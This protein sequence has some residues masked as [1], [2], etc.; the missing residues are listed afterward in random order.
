M[1]GSKFSP[2][3][4]G[5][6]ELTA[7]AEEVPANQKVY[8]L[9]MERCTSTGAPQIFERVILVTAM[10]PDRPA[11][12]YCRIKVGEVAYMYGKIFGD[13]EKNRKSIAR[14]ESASLGICN[15]F[16]E[17]GFEVIKS[18]AIAMPNDYQLLD[19]H[20][21]CLKYDKDSD[22]YQLQLYGEEN[23]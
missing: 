4:I 13:E 15:Y 14:S 12:L 20:A 21:A 6:A 19:G 3:L 16:E 2:F 22:L 23:D 1:T 18:A 10:A 11:I 8:V 9:N 17:L 5:Y 7:M